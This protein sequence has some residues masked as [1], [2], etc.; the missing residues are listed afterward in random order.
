[1]DRRTF[2]LWMLAARLHSRRPRGL[3]MRAEVEAAGGGGVV[4]RR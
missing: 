2:T 3:L 1:M 4:W